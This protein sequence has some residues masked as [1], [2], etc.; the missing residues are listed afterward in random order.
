MSHALAAFDA[1]WAI[2]RRDAQLFVSYRLRFAAQG[3]AIL[4]SVAL[5][6]YV[7]QLVNVRSF[8]TPETYFAYV[9]VGLATIELLTASL[10][11]VP[12]ALRTELVG[13]TFERLVVSP[14]G[15]IASVLAMTVFPVLLS[16]VIALATVLM[17]VLLFGLDLQ[18][19]TA[20][21]ALVVAP[22][23]A[24]SF[25]PFTLLLSSAVLLFKQAGGAAAFVTTGLSLASG[26]FFPAT[27]LPSWIS[28]LRDVQPLSPALELMRHVLVG[29][30]T[31]QS[32]ELEALRLVGFAVIGT[33]LALLAL[34]HVIDTCRR[35]GTL[36]EY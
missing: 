30:P 22:L 16:L 15:P 18:W 9:V 2:V 17:A 11:A 29:A 4:F 32:P 1:G 23:A 3:V 24:L 27:L 36:T 25:L 31:R 14:L 10:A 19:S 21:L 5:F 13:G 26:A 7:S 33:P 6:Y 20:P 12:N 28:W 8:P 34:R 35:R